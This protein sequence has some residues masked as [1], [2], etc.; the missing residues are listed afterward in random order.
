LFLVAFLPRVLGLETFITAD[1]DDQIMFSTLFLNS[2]LQGDLSNALVLGYPGV[3]TLMLGALGVGLRYLFHYAGWL[4]L[5]WVTGDL[6]S[7]LSQVTTQFGVFEYPLDFLVWVRA[8]MV[9][10]ASLSIVGIY[11]L[12]KQLLADERLALLAGLLIAF[13]PFILAH[14]RVIHVDGPMSYFMF[15]AF[16]AFLLYVEQG[17]W[18]WLL[19]SGLCAGLAALS[20]TPAALLG[21]ILVASGLCYVLLPSASVQPGRWR[22]LGL[23]LLGCGAIAAVAFFA[24]WPAM[25]TRPLY[26]IE[27]IIGNIRSVNRMAHPT[28]GVFWGAYQTDQS[29]LYYLT[30]F[31]YHLT[32][33]T[34]VGLAGGL[35]VIL[36]GAVARL[37]KVES[38][39]GRVLP[40]A[41][42]LVIYIVLFIAP[43]SLISRRGDRYILPVF[44]AAGLLAALGLWGLALRVKRLLP[45][46]PARAV[47]GA[48]LLQAIFVLLYHPYYL[49]YYNP[50]LSYYRPAPYALNIGWGEG[51]DVAARY[52]NDLN[53]AQGRVG[54]DAPQVAAWYSAQFAPYYH[55]PT[56]DLSNQG[57]ALTGEYTVFYLNQVQ[58]GF[59]SAEVLDYFRQRTP[60]HV[61]R[62]DGVKYAWIYEGPVISTEPPQNVSF[63]AGVLFGGGAHLLGLDVAERS[64]PADAFSPATPPGNSAENLL[65]LY[66][67]EQAGLPITLYWETVAEI[68]GDQNVYIRLVDEQGNGWGQVDRMILAGL[69]RPDRWPPGYFIRDDYRLLIDPATPPGRYHFEVGM[70]DFVTSHSYGVAKKIGEITLTPPTT[71]P[72]ADQLNIEKLSTPINEALTL[73]GHTYGDQHAP[74][75]AEVVGKIFWQA[76]QPI[77]NEY[78]LEF[79]FISPDRRKYGV[80]EIA[81]SP[82]YPLTEWRTGETVGAAYRWRIPALAP[83]GE[84][85][86]VVGLVD[87]DTGKTVGVETTLATITVEARQRNFTLPQEVTPV[88]VILGDEIELVGYRLHDKTVRPKE[89]FGL[90]LYWRS[91]RPIETNYTAFVHAIGPDQVMRG[92][93]DSMP[94]QGASPTGGWLPG[95][96]VADHYAVPMAK[97]APPWSYDIFVGMYDAATGQRLP[98]ASL[99]SPLSDN[100]A[101][102]GRVQVVT[103]PIP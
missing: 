98:A 17:G 28:T 33:L 14:T 55:G 69:W 87:P 3:P 66:H 89:S 20:K 48:I 32:P 97:D 36:A 92:Q 37:R 58:R 103:S 15:L 77:A 24:L 41:V 84:Y 102:L 6:M 82:S 71:P 96:I 53:A 81:L 45:I 19:L 50:I 11:A 59:P 22:R 73:V 90:T 51:L 52:L 29:Y 16:L 8:P 34:M 57:A 25:W 10:V 91:L 78:R 85:P 39:S 42:S 7:T 26:A 94:G 67:D 54:D 72:S 9:L 31:P 74:P 101:W 46:T 100:R 88:S 43:I 62:L 64:M 79:A 30:V 18:R 95:E 40:L 99:E 68:D 12:L 13:D 93:W 47:E 4:P 35:G 23:A 65:P 60:L 70:Y 76:R 56:L 61:V 75:G 63:P 44:F 49:A 83:P 1:E 2:L 27:W 21:P 86:L 80:A 38:W 5:P